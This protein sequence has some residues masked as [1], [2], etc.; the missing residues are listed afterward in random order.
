MR[1]V[2]VDTFRWITA[3]K[4]DDAAANYYHVYFLDTHAAFQEGWDMGFD[5]A[6]NTLHSDKEV[7]CLDCGS[8]NTVAYLTVHSN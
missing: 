3:L 6:V 2:T 4:P 5:Q 7:S 1:K 8:T